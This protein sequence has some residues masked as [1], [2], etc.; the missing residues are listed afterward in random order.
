MWK[1]GPIEEGNEREGTVMRNRATPA[2]ARTRRSAIP[3]AVALA[4][5]T[6][7]WAPPA[8][9]TPVVDQSFTSPYNLGAN[10]NEG[11]KYIGQSFTAGMTGNLTAVNLD[12]RS[13]R[14]DG[15]PPLRVAIRTVAN[16][17]PYGDPLGFRYLYYPQAPLS[18][19]ITFRQEIPVVAGQ[20]YAIVVS[21]RGSEPGA[22][23]ALGFW[24]GA[25]GD[26]YPG[27]RM[28]A[29]QCPSYSYTGFW[30]VSTGWASYDLHFRTYVEPAT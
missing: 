14:S 20:Q 19:L 30:Y 17:K 22:G 24:Y 16:N 4:L 21:Y 12:Q 25:T 8:A 28:F 3:A 2:T 10:I 23:Q 5:L 18:R 6:V 13:I 7:T 1:L 9:A 15:T 26:P 29:G 11:C 27:G